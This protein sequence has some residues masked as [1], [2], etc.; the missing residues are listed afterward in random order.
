MGEQEEQ[1]IS[2]EWDEYFTNICNGREG[3][4]LDYLSQFICPQ[5]VGKEWINIRKVLLLQLLTKND[6][7]YRMRLNTLL[8]GEPGTGKTE[9][10]LWWR[11]N[12]EGILI[13]GELCS[14]TGLV[15]DARG[16]R[17]TPGLLADYDG[18]MILVDELDK[19]NM[20]DSNGLLQAMEEGQYFIVKGKHRQPFKAEIRVIASVNEIDKVP[21]PLL[22]RFDFVY[23]CTT[24]SRE[25]RAEQVQ[26]IVDSFIGKN[27][28]ET[29]ILKAYVRWLGD[30]EPKIMPEDVADV[31][32]TIRTY[33]KKAKGV[34]IE[35]VSYRSLEW[36]VLRIAHALTKLQK[37]NI[38]RKDAE[39]AFF[40]KH[41]T[42]LKIYPKVGEE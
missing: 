23:K 26:M 24:A 42:L 2:P 4:P 20:K 9:V 34:K 33:I 35:K 11:E 19:M 6:S 27:E 14:K 38:E 30:F 22:D 5:L 3:H 25:E 1:K 8:E 31:V 10:M 15:G 18:H 32:E 41:K 13:N 40:I 12:L 39:E 37:K 29:N 28:E 17:V 7:N 36:S 16:N 21:K